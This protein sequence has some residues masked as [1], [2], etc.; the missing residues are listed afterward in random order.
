MPPQP[1]A[2]SNQFQFP[3][4]T[5]QQSA[6]HRPKAAPETYQPAHRDEGPQSG[7]KTKR[8]A[9]ERNR[10]V[11]ATGTGAERPGTSGRLCYLVVRRKTHP[12]DSQRK[13]QQATTAFDLPCLSR[14]MTL[15][16]IGSPTAQRPSPLAALPAQNSDAAGGN[17][18]SSAGTGHRTERFMVISL[19]TNSVVP[20]YGK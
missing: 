18:E 14:S 2:A 4:R 5:E 7:L 3:A 1:R 8:P 12:C 15:P 10:P 17:F 13:R 6:A 9:D 19:S 16:S 20:V 11:S